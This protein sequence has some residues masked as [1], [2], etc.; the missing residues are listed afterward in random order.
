MRAS[1]SRAHPFI[2]QGGA[3]ALASAHAGETFGFHQTFHPFAANTGAL[4]GHSAWMRG[5]P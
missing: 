1:A 3:T 5:A 2:T 4:I